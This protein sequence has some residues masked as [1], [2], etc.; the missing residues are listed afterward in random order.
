MDVVTEAYFVVRSTLIRPGE[1]VDFQVELIVYK[2]LEV[3]L[4]LQFQFYLSTDDSFNEDDT[5]VNSSTIYSFEL[6]MISSHH[7]EHP[8]PRDE[9]H[10]LRDP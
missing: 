10:N 5:K 2:H 1:A 9:L 7:A 3:P 4:H 8:K 6:N